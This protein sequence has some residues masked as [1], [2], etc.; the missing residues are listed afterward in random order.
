MQFILGVS[1]GAGLSSRQ[2]G[3]EY[4]FD[5]NKSGF[6]SALTSQEGSVLSVWGKS[7]K[8]SVV[9]LSH[10]YKGNDLPTH[11]VVATG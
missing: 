1:P 4:N 6:D 8:F 2:E 11:S 5:I 7:L 9:Q 3:Q 10:L